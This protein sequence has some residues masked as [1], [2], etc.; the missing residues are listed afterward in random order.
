MEGCRT[1]TFP[2]GS[3]V[4][5]ARLA[6]NGNFRFVLLE[7]CFKVDSVP[8]LCSVNSPALISFIK[9]TSSFHLLAVAAALFFCGLSF[10]ISKYITL[11]KE[12]QHFFRK[13]LKKVDFLSTA[14]YNAYIERR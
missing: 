9:I 11:W 10:H 12:S 14:W 1:R 6:E 7:L 2:A 5:F 3:L 13:K 4:S 8:T